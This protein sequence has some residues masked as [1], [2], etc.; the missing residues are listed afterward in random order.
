MTSITKEQVTSETV[1]RYQGISFAI[2]TTLSDYDQIVIDVPVF[3]G[4]YNTT[5]GNWQSVPTG[6]T[7]KF[8][9][10]KL[11]Y[12]LVN[13]KDNSVGIY[14]LYGRGFT[15]ANNLRVQGH[16]YNNEQITDEIL[17]QIP[18]HYHDKA[19]EQFLLTA[20]ELTEQMN[21]INANGLSLIPQKR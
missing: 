2:E 14:S 21:T 19:K 5:T 11:E 16:G 13:R 20:K 6:E 17:A 3:Q 18:D 10:E 15:K 12:N 7:V 8:R 9:L 4:G 1:T